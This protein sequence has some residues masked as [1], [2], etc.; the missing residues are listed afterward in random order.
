MFLSAA[1]IAY[2]GAFTGQFRQDLVDGW[3]A[4]CK[5][6]A[7]PVSGDCTLRGVLASPVEVRL[8]LGL[9][10]KGSVGSVFGANHSSGPGSFSSQVAGSRWLQTCGVWQGAHALWCCRSVSGGRGAY[11]QMTSPLT[12]ASW[13]RGASAGL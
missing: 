2:Y 5:E 6:L 10:L 8:S 12:T 7:I 4:R 3:I 1:C 11:P 13:S 9:L